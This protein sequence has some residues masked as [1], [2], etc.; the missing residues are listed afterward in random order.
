MKVVASALVIA[1][2]AVGIIGI[3][4]AIRHHE[5]EVVSKWIAVGIGLLAVGTLLMSLT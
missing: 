3:S 1:G 5:G 4:L 2:C